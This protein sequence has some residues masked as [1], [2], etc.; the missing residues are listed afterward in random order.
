MIGGNQGQVQYAQGPIYQTD[1]F[2]PNAPSGS[3]WSTIGQATNK[4][5]YHSGALLLESGHVV[6]VGSEFDNYDDFYNPQKSECFEDVKAPH[7]GPKLGP[8]CTDPFNYNIERFTPPYLMKGPGPVITKAPSTVTYGSLIEISVKSTAGIARATL[9]RYSSLTH[10]TNTDQR[11]I[12]LIIKGSKAAENKLYISFPEN[13]AL[14]PP[15]NWML[16]LLNENGVPS[17]AS[18]IM[19]KIGKPDIANFV[20]VDPEPKTKPKTNDTPVI[21][22]FGTFIASILSFFFLA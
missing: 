8:G 15:G 21:S 4:R 7:T 13:S 19:L 22:W 11:F 3:K 10:S 16:F 6:T 14:A 9:I 17:T 18:S 12:E 2:K 5:L 1:L 20:I